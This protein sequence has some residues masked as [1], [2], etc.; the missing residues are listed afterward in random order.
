MTVSQTSKDA[1]N[2]VLKQAFQV[3]GAILTFPPKDR[4]VGG[5]NLLIMSMVV[6]QPH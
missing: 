6:E 4:T 1:V 5:G 3:K 2:I